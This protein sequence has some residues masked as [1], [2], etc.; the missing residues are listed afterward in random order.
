LGLVATDDGVPPG[1]KPPGAGT[2]PGGGGSGPP[3]RPNARNPTIASTTTPPAAPPIISPALPPPLDFPLR[4]PR[5]P[6]PP[7]RPPGTSMSSPQSLHGTVSP[8]RSSRNLYRFPQPGHSTAMGM[9]NLVGSR[10]CSRVLAEHRKVAL[11][12]GNGTVRQELLA[13]I[14]CQFLRAQTIALDPKSRPK[15]MKGG[16]R[17]FPPGPRRWDVGLRRKMDAEKAH[18]GFRVT[19]QS[20]WGR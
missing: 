11:S 4:R 9:A 16:D 20:I 18:A 2:P 10:G 8:A 3:P 7:R 19:S 12:F 15:M 13:A 17:T 1:A 5:D 14:C 6:P